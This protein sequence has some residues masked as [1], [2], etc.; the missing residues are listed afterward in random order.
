MKF[1]P[2]LHDR[3]DVGWGFVQ[4]GICRVWVRVWEVGEVGTIDTSFPGFSLLLQDTN[5]EHDGGRG[6]GSSASFAFWV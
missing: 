5:L 4:K 2:V 1:H 3:V 6:D